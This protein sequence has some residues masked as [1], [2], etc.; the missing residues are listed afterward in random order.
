[1]LYGKAPGNL[2][3][4][5]VALVVGMAVGNLLLVHGTSLTSRLITDDG[6]G[7][8]LLILP[9]AAGVGFVL[10]GYAAFRHGEQVEEAHE[11]TRKASVSDDKASWL[12]GI[13]GGG[14]A[15]KVAD[16]LR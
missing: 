14:I 12:A 15:A 7:A 8:A 13:P 2:L 6:D 3:Y 4:R 16:W 5:A 10:G 9:I 1:M 11:E